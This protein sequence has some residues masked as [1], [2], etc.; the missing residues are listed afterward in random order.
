[1]VLACADPNTQITMTSCGQGQT[2][3]DRGKIRPDRP[4]ARCRAGAGHEYV[5]VPPTHRHPIVFGLAY[6]NDDCTDI[7]LDPRFKTLLFKFMVRVGI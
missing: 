5:N 6:A 2:G 7:T 4:E 1:M 3:P